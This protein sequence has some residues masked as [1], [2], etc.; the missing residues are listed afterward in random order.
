MCQ[1]IHVVVFT[2]FRLSNFTR[3]CVATR[4]LGTRPRPVGYNA[5]LYLSES[6]G[7]GVVPEADDI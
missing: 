1:A 3:S 2:V 7:R 5:R 4:R 6:P